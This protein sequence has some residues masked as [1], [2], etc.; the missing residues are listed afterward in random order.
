MLASRYPRRETWLFDAPAKAADNDKQNCT[1]IDVSL[2]WSGDHNTRFTI[3]KTCVCVCVCVLVFASRKIELR[4][5]ENLHPGSHD[6]AQ[7]SGMF[8]TPPSTR[9]LHP[10]QDQGSRGAIYQ[11][12]LAATL[13]LQD[14]SARLRMSCMVRVPATPRD[15]SSAKR[16]TFFFS[17]LSLTLCLLLPCP[18]FPCLPFL[19]LRRGTKWKEQDPWGGGVEG[20]RK[21]CRNGGN[22]PRSR[23]S[24]RAEIPAWDFP[25]SMA[26]RG[27]YSVH[28]HVL[29]AGLNLASPGRAGWILRDKRERGGS[30][31][32]GWG[33]EERKRKSSDVRVWEV[34]PSSSLVVMF[35][36]SLRKALTG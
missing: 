26:R 11:G 23:G 36:W 9:R 21:S 31:G 12:P 24:L 6:K 7:S 16:S 25:R 18:P 33:E 5:R 15:W 3:E 29:A 8:I 34:L 32:G 28:S 2:P 30:E 4:S 35:E 27:E 19:P 22:K 17:L 20:D 1:M 10:D 13:P 14:L